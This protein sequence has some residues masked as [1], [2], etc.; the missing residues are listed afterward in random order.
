ML[1]VERTM[2]SEDPSSLLNRSLQLTRSPETEV[3][4]ERAKRRASIASE[5][6]KTPKGQLRYDQ[7]WRGEKNATNTW[8]SALQEVSEEL[9]KMKVETI[10]EAAQQCDKNRFV[11]V[12]TF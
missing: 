10:F 8:Q 9:N 5:L 3:A 11:K 6:R 12:C 7:E 1:L 4:Q 2:G